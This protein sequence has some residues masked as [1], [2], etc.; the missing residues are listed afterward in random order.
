MPRNRVTR[1]DFLRVSTVAGAAAFAVPALVHARSPNEKL[2]VAVIGVG[3]HGVKQLDAAGRLEN[4]VAV[5]DTDEQTLG[6]TAQGYPKAKTYYDFRKMLG[7]LEKSIDAVMVSTPDHTHAPISAMAMRMGKHCYCEKPLTHDVYEARTLTQLA[8]Q[9]NLVTQMGTQMHACQNYRRV[10]ELIRA[11][12]IGPVTEARLWFGKSWGTGVR[13]RETQEPPKH[14]HWDLWLGPAPFRP[15]N[16]CYLP[17]SW[18]CWWDFGN[19]TFGDMSCHIMDLAFWALDLRH[20]SSIEAEGPPV[21]AE[22]TPTKL[23]VRYEFPA[24]GQQPPVKL[25]W[26]DGDQRPDFL[27]GVELP[28]EP[29]GVLFKG[30]DGLLWAGYD[31]RQLYPK[32]KF[33]GFKAPPPSI[34]DSV[35]H[36]EEFFRACKTGGPT[37]CN[38]DY[39][40][41][42]TEAALLGTVA[43]RV[44]KRLEWDA[45]SLKA[46]NCP[47]ADRYLR[48]PYRDGWTL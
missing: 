48:R 33:K 18:R 38:F 41:A 37:T 21:D 30:R 45:D 40:G 28:S 3:R 26:C 11:G 29:I 12:T 10:V 47:Q 13:P 7:E 44:G 24:R 17:G 4:V 19:G 16:P 34:P 32:E 35:G 9:K 2:N 43:Y 27:T 14:L 5:C 31:S 22:G 46:V 1:R 25:T 36:H 23:T 8:K 20:P 39:S 42:L 15:Y 6:H